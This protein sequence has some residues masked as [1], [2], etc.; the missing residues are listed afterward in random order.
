MVKEV[1]VIKLC[2]FMRKLNTI[3]PDLKSWNYRGLYRRGCE[4][5]SE[6][7]ERKRWLGIRAKEIERTTQAICSFIEMGF[8][9]NGKYP[10]S[11]FKLLIKYYIVLMDS[12]RFNLNYEMAADDIFENYYPIEADAS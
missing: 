9:D 3:Y 4:G 7:S 2:D 1:S 8:E 5:F 12:E 10:E 11:Y 6:D